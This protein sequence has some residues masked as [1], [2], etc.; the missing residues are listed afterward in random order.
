MM[1]FKPVIK[2]LLVALV[3]GVSLTTVHASDRGGLRSGSLE[4]FEAAAVVERVNSVEL[5]ANGKKYRYDTSLKFLDGS[6]KSSVSLLETGDHVWLK[7]K[8][9]NGVLYIESMSVLPSNDDS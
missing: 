4:G 5:T 6:L 8:T 2:N 3:L 1:W 9:L 7:G